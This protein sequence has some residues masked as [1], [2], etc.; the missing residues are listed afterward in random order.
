MGPFL[1]L[2]CVVPA[3]TVGIFGAHGG[4]GRELVEQSR[5]RAHVPVAFVRRPSEHIY[6]PVRQGWLDP[7]EP[8]TPVPPF[9]NLTVRS[10]ESVDGASLA[11]LDAAV[12]VMS[13]RPFVDDTSDG[14]VRRACAALPERCS[15]VCLVSAWG[16]GGSIA[17][18]NVG[19][20]VMRGGYLRSVYRAKE[21]QEELVREWE[22]ACPKR[23][24]ALVLRP[25][26]L[27]YA[28]IPFNPFATPR[29]VL[30]FRILDWVETR[31]TNPM[32]F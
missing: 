1:L 22:D 30:A 17:S 19:I 6:P 27:S 31:T 5:E 11:D 2:P 21:T 25:K 13:G 3:L 8:R 32:H 26:V 14:V 12:F 23:R 10:T 16:V 29:N 7:L 28:P 20:K 4:L 9:R 24:A 15:R 18:A